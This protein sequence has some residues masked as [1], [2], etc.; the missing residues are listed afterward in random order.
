MVQPIK[1]GVIGSGFI[2]PLHVESLRRLGWVEVIGL[3]G[4]NEE[5]AR[6]SA[7]ELSIPKAY[8]R[9]QDLVN[10]PDV[11]VIHNCTPNNL[12]FAI[13]QAV[14][15]AG[16][17]LV[18]EKPVGMTSKESG[19]LLRLAAQKRS[20]NLVCYTYRMYPVIQQM[21]EMVACG[22]V[23]KPWSVWGVYLQDWLSRETDYNW[24][25]DP[26]VSGPTRVMGDIGSHWFE[27][28]QFIL[29]QNITSVCAE[30]TTVFPTR[31]KAQQITKSF[32]QAAAEAYDN[33][34]V[35]TEDIGSVMLRF[36]DG[37][38]GTF[39]ASQVATG[40]K[41]YIHVEVAGSQCSIAWNHEDAE[42]L[43]IGRRM[44]P[45][46]HSLRDGL[47]YYPEA[48][49]YCYYPAG[50]PQG[51][52]SGFKNLFYA[53]YKSLREGRGWSAIQPDFPT[54]WEGHRTMLILDALVTSAR[55]HRWVDI[56]LTSM[57]DANGSPKP[58]SYGA[59]S[60]ESNTSGELTAEA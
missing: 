60:I 52:S 38:V 44:E 39:T 40:R 7:D 24:R 35:S 19:D 26:S 53:F 2:G 45:N 16:K 6:K 54:L 55:E 28:I 50:H 11:Q 9:W 29:G 25:V 36:E 51:Y 31:K 34:P 27:V 15:E 5:H 10:D 8:G 49:K 18:M 46:M 4:E 1:V 56:D 43:W 22:D 17:P 14:L 23:G 12:H 59:R 20:P 13:N 47:L 21:K 30:F 41:N 48:Q 58:V 33:V 37:L 3:A 42:R 57:H 32:E